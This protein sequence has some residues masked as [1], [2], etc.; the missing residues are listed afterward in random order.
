MYVNFSEEGGGL[1]RRLQC[2][3]R[4][5]DFP[6]YTHLIWLLVSVLGRVFP[7]SL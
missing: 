5:L 3:G 4:M 1:E 2:V 7:H 6:E